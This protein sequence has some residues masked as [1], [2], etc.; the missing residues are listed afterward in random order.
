MA[1]SRHGHKAFN[2]FLCHVF[3]I[4]LLVLILTYSILFSISA[5][6]QTA[7]PLNL[8]IGHAELTALEWSSSNSKEQAIIALPWGG[9]TAIGYRYL[10]PLLA[11]AGYRLIALNPRGFSGS[12]GT[13][14]ELSLH[15]YAADVAAVVALLELDQVHMM[16]SALGNRVA[17][18]VATDHPNLVASISL[19]AAGGMVTPLVS[20]ENAGRLFQ[21]P[22]LAEE[23]QLAF[24]RD[25][26]FA[27]STPTAIVKEFIDNL[28]YFR[29]ASTAR[30]GANRATPVEQWWAGGTAP[31]LIVQGL[32][33]K[34]APPQ[35]GVLMQ[36]QFGERIRVV[37]LEDAGHL[38]GLEKPQ[39]VSAAVI[40]FLEAHAF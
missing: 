35:N 28:G 4:F 29:E 15:D 36:E 33:D 40:E 2:D 16:G 19:I 30:S 31:M 10:G 18:A 23:L 21:D 8:N 3:P 20:M 34:I 7:K 22:D 13:L 14:G 17:R 37:N 11:D 26:L 39:E 12:T 27:E 24:A 38:M 1:Q 25:T 32:D 9:G 5:R 6:A